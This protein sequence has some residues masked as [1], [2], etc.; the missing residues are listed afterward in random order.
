MYSDVSQCLQTS[1]VQRLKCRRLD[2]GVHQLVPA[3]V[4][5]L[6]GVTL[7]R[8]R[9]AL[10]VTPVWWHVT[11]PRRPRMLLMFEWSRE[12]RSYG[13]HVEGTDGR[14]CD[15]VATETRLYTLH[16]T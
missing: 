2:C 8:S 3:R 15:A 11:F 13:G 4:Q 12:G 1:R 14:S 5:Q 7:G 16:E 9:L 10:R 6:V